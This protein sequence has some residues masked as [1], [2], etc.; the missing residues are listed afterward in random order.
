MNKI[1]FLLF[2]P[3]YSGAEIIIKNLIENNNDIESYVLVSKDYKNKIGKITFRTKYI[4]RLERENNLICNTIFRFLSNLYGLTKLLVQLQKNHHFDVIHINNLTLSIYSLPAALYFRYKYPF[5][6][7]VWHSQNIN[8]FEGDRIKVLERLVRWTFNYTIVVSDA[9]R[10]K[11]GLNSSKI[12]LIYSGIDTNKFKFNSKLRIELRKKY[13]IENRL[14]IGI[15]GTISF[16]KG[17]ISL[18]RVFSEIANKTKLLHLIIIGNFSSPKIREQILNYEENI[19][20]DKLTI[21]SNVNNIHGY[22]SL[23]DIII[24]NTSDILSEPL[25]TT[26][27]E[28]M[29]C[30]NIVLASRTGGTPEIIDEGINGFMFSPDNLYELERKLIYIIENFNNLKFIQKNARKKIVEKFDINNMVQNFNNIILNQI[31]ENT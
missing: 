4:S 21:L 18:L 17:Q 19:D 31:N 6:M 26:I 1:L 12:K 23:T 11:I 16:L 14:V 7:L 10:R 28:G 29:A 2:T 27:L 3:R 24:N 20:K 15:F 25:G 5:L 13:A 22:Y 9:V 8:Y 30:E